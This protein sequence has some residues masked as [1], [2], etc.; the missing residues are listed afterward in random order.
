[1]PARMTDGA[2]QPR[3]QLDDVL[4][5]PQVAH[6]HVVHQR[7]GLRVGHLK[8]EDSDLREQV[9]VL[10]IHSLEAVVVDACARQQIHVRPDQL[11]CDLNTGRR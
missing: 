1:M 2:D 5:F 8:F 6:Q 4:R 11:F 10:P 3:T 9:E 7:L